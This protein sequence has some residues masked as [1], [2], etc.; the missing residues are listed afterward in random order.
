MDRVCLNGSWELYPA[1]KK[2]IEKYTNA[3][4]TNQR[5]KCTLPGDIHSA[6]IEEKIIPDPYF[7]TNELDIQWVGKC[8]WILEREFQI[9]KTEN[10]SISFTFL[11]TVADVY[12]NDI[13]AIK[14][15]NMFRKWDADIS[16]K[17]KQGTNKIKIYFHSAEKE[18][19]KESEKLPYPIPYSEYPVFSPYRNLIRKAQCHS[20][21]DWGPCI[22]SMGVYEEISILSGKTI[23]NIEKNIEITNIKD[24]TWKVNVDI[25]CNSEEAKDS[26]LSLKVGENTT[27]KSIVL[28]KG[29]NEFSIGI[30]IENPSLWYPAGIGEQ[31]LYDMTLV[32]DGNVEDERKI[33]FRNLEC[34]NEKDEKGGIS[35]YFKV[36]GKKIF[37]K[38][39]NWIPIDALPK[40][41]T[42][43]RYEKLL[44]NMLTCNM[45]IVRV[46]GGGQYE[47]DFFYSLCDELGILI[48]QD[49]M[50]ACAMYPATD[51]FLDNVRK[52]IEY[53]VLRLKMHPSI[54]IWCGNN[55]DLGAIGWYEESKN[56][57]ERYLEDYE[58]LNDQTI[59][60]IV[61]ELDPKRRWW[62][63]SPSA[64]EGDYS[65]NWHS[66]NKGDMHYWS[67]WH[68][69]KPFS[70]YYDIKPRF[71]SEFGFQSFPTMKTVKSFTPKDEFF[72]NSKSML[73]HQKNPKGNEIIA[74]TMEYYYGL[75]KDFSSIVYLSQIQQAEAMRIAI[76]YYRSLMPYTMGTIY[77]QLNDNW[78]VASWSSIDYEGNWKALQYMAKRFY[79]PIHLAS[80]LIDGKASIAL[81][82]ESEEQI[83]TKLEIIKYSFDGKKID[84]Y[85]VDIKA[86][87]CSASKCELRFIPD[88]KSYIY[89]N[90]KTKEKLLSTFLLEERPKNAQLE[91]PEISISA[92][93]IGAK[94]IELEIEC[95][96]PV[97]YLMIETDI[98]GVFSDNA[99][100]LNAGE[101][102]KITFQSDIEIKENELISSLNVQHLQNIRR[103]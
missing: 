84:S 16:D 72:V 40:R 69:G 77:W 71:V 9:E 103:H 14:A 68:E 18:A 45:N 34:V 42:K 50:F 70:A 55:E 6:L 62:P 64:G 78:P 76:E 89:A 100:L 56:N 93:Q 30:S 79:E 48:W 88:S 101:K 29:K 44:R 41:Q 28:V 13:I 31:S 22:L 52:E 26:M 53:Q 8:D 51:D 23:S 90:A 11:D 98:K 60:K 38:G 37:S 2:E 20:G 81:I 54:A 95:K 87:A 57:R 35:L 97:F 94:T 74:S 4:K 17:L 59:G 83:E 96:K 82:N 32:I 1:H 67:V 3:F 66:D 15:N 33:G 36:N 58:K 25:K 39:A 46:W 99:L 24:N 65:D 102:T 86:N 80:M 63:S 43:D 19:M 12:I 10:S 73:H 61:K 49:M 27:E 47:Y 75:P 21:W 5:I 91:D 92:N 7:G 85:L